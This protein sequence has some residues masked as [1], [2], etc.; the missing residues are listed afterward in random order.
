M[1]SFYIPGKPVAKGRHRIGKGGDGKAMAF[2][3]GKTASFENMVSYLAAEQM[4]GKPSIQHAV[5]LR[6]YISVRP[7][8]SWPEW[9]RQAAGDTTM[10]PTGKPDIDNIIKS[11]MDGMNRIVWV[12]DD[13]VMSVVSYKVFGESDG[14]QVEVQIAHAAPS[15]VKTK[16]MLHEFLP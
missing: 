11:V 8:D 5:I 9:K 15:K 16:A 4:Q 1:I 13:Q 14:T 10:V 12:D 3:D 6:V 7:S 2:K